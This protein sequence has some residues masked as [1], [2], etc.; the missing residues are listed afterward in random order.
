MKS[1]YTILNIGLNPGIGEQIAIGLIVVSSNGVF[2]KYSEKKLHI[3][4]GLIP[5]NTAR[6]IKSELKNIAVMIHEENENIRR[7]ISESGS[8]ISRMFSEEY[9]SYL[10]HSSKN[11][12]I[13]SDPAILS[14]D[15]NSNSFK[16]LFEKF[17]YSFP[18]EKEPRI[19]YRESVKRVLYPKIKNNVNTDFKLRPSHIPNLPF[20]IDL[21]FIGK[22]GQSV[23]GKIVDFELKFYNL[24]SDLTEY[25]SLIKI[26]EMN[27]ESGIY[28]LIANEPDKTKSEQHKVWREIYDMKLMEVVP[29]EEVEV[30]SKYIIDQNV[31]PFTT[32]ID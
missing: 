2:F 1:Y 26:I 20:P 31:I 14:I 4:S 6:H 24:K 9:F 12:I 32:E 3:V 15:F 11:L 25:I 30:I 23:M 19:D 5:L 18:E 22:N 17:I 10:A 7:G 28:Y 21:N 27:K 29:E 16:I 13:F 8:N